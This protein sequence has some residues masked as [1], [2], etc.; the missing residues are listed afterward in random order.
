MLSPGEI[1]PV[2]DGA[3]SSARHANIVL[4]EANESSGSD[5]DQITSKL[6]ACYHARL[7]ETAARLLADRIAA[8]ER[9]AKLA[10]TAR[11][12]VRRAAVRNNEPIETSS[13]DDEPIHVG[14]RSRSAALAAAARRI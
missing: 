4:E 3:G 2:G 6:D 10:Q 14:H 11:T 1:V 7:G 8:K 13:D 5:D 12:A 9:E